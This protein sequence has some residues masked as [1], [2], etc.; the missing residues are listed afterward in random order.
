MIAEEL[1][2]YLALQGHGTQNED[3]FLGFQPDSPDDCVV[4]YDETTPVAEESNALSVDQFGIQVLV[5]NST[6]TGAR[7]L[8]MEIH[9]D[10]VGFG[11]Q[12]F[13]EG[14]KL[15]HV[16]FV[17]TTPTSIGKDSKG[18]SEWSAHYITRVESVG[19]SYRT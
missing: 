2:K 6:Y 7:D 18:R 8:I 3:L 19:D 9:R 1:A 15:V 14:G 13:I 17:S 5:R 4:V 16:V 11:G 10:L 12:S